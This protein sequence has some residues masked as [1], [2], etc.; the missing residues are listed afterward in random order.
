[1]QDG[2]LYLEHDYLFT[3]FLA[4]LNEHTQKIKDILESIEIDESIME[5]YDLSTIYKESKSHLKK[6]IA[7]EESEFNSKIFEVLK[8][9]YLKLENK[10]NGTK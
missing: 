6:L 10:N 9:S 4:C 7:D 1:L 2:P 3:N 5:E 8:L